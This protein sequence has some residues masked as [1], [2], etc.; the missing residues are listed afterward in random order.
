MSLSPIQLPC[1]PLQTTA[2]STH[3]DYVNPWLPAPAILKSAA[4]IQLR[5]ASTYSA[6]G[7]TIQRAPSHKVESLHYQD[8]KATSFNTKGKPEAF[9]NYTC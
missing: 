1:L 2:T 3:D 5:I 9:A 6:P 4:P 7:P 8:F